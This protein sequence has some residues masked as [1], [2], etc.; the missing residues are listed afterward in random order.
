[1]VGP[2][3]SF[4]CDIH[5]DGCHE[6]Q[7]QCYTRCVEIVVVV[8]VVVYEEVSFALYRCGNRRWVDKIAFFSHS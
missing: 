2:T 5:V 3:M 7:I 6:T 1:M 4:P 8:V